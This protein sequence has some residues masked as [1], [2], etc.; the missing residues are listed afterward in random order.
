MRISIDICITNW[1]LTLSPVYTPQRGQTDI[2]FLASDDFSLVE[3]SECK[4]YPTERGAVF[5]YPIC[6]LTA[7]V[8][9]EREKG[10]CRE[11]SLS[12]LGELLSSTRRT[13][14]FLT[15]FLLL[16]NRLT[17]TFAEMR[18]LSFHLE[19]EIRI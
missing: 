17:Q 1:I 11:G 9:Q 4:V 10:K 2:L 12:T 13:W 18:S 14:S 8:K 7:R 3:I 19:V 16:C 5:I 6:Q 15:R